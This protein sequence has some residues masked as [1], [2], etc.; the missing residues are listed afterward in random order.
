MGSGAAREL[1]GSADSERVLDPEQNARLGAACLRLDGADPEFKLNRDDTRNMQRVMMWTALAKVVDGYLREVGNVLYRA[2]Q[3][4]LDIGVEGAGQ[5]TKPYIEET[6]R[7]FEKLSFRLHTDGEVH[8]TM[9]NR[10]IS[11]VSLEQLTY[12]WVEAAAVDWLVF[13][14]EG[15]K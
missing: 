5:G 4:S 6:A 12:E 10:S 11:H 7:K 13:T 14:A 2:Q 1:G 3:L 15:R 9:G 8:A